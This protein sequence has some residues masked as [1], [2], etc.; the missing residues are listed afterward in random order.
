M[1]EEIGSGEQGYD[2]QSSWNFYGWG[3]RVL[4]PGDAGDAVLALEALEN[5]ETVDEAFWYK[6]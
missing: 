4:A 5:S 1:F 3:D 2:L 6:G